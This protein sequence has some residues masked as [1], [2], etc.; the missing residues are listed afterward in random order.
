MNNKKIL[1]LCVSIF[2]IFIAGCNLSAEG[3]NKVPYELEGKFL[4]EE[5]STEYERGAVN[6]NFKNLSDKTVKEVYI[7]FYL[8]DEESTPLKNNM[9]AA[10]CNIPC[11]EDSDFFIVFDEY[12]S[13][14]VKV[15]EGF[16]LDFMYASKIIYED[17]S[18]WTDPMGLKK[19]M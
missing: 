9:I 3:I 12:L 17:G 4:C 8:F 10:T 13:D 7:V 5:N 6:Y 2:F 18:E 15:N 1:G 16:Y 11:N 19:F 14:D